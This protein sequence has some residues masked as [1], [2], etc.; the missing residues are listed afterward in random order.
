MG[1]EI[2][3]W[4]QLNPE[5]IC[6]FLFIVSEI[7]DFKKIRIIS[8]TDRET[9]NLRWDDFEKVSKESIPLTETKYNFI[10]EKW[11]NLL[12]KPH[13]LRVYLNGEIVGVDEDFYDN[14]IYNNLPNDDFI[15]H[16]LMSNLIDSNI[17]FGSYD[18]EV[19][20]ICEVLRSKKVEVVGRKPIIQS[21]LD[22]YEQIYHKK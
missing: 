6:N 19:K 14:F 20:R 1:D 5:A 9:H 17:C 16:D 10:I 4:L 22:L 12:K 7:Q 11:N 8:L 3:I 18:F 21:P 13:L 15:A 2:L